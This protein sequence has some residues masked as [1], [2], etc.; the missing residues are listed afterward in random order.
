VKES[1][2]ISNPEYSVD[3]ILAR[4]KDAAVRKGEI[5][6]A[7]S[8]DVVTSAEFR[9]RR[10]ESNS[11]SEL[12]LQPIQLQ[13]RFHPNTDSRYH[14]NDLLKFHDK[15]FIQNAYRAI[16]KRGPDAVG[17]RNFLE[18]LRAAR[19]NKID[20]LARLRYSAEGKAK[21]VEVE[22]LW[23]PAMIRKA[24]RV[25]YV[26]YLLNMLVGVAR[27][28]VLI[29]NQQQFE[30]HMLAQQDIIVEHLNHLNRTLLTHANEVLSLAERSEQ[31][32][33]E[34]REQINNR[35]DRGDALFRHLDARID[36][37]RTSRGEGI[38]TIARRL[39]QFTTRH[40]QLELVLKLK[41]AQFQQADAN[42]RDLID[43]HRQQLELL[44]EQ[45]D[46]ITRQVKTELSRLIEKQQSLNTE[47]V[48]QAERLTTVLDEAR[49]RLPEPFD[50]AQLQALAKEANHT[51]D[52]FYAS[53]DEKFR[54]SRDEIKK[55]LRIYLPKIRE[56]E[57][58][59]ESMP[60]L[61][62]GSGRGEWLEL[63]NE[64]GI[65]ARGVDSNRILVEDCLN[66]GLNVVEAD[67]VLHLQQLADSSIGAVTGFHIIEHLPIETLVEFLNQTVRVLKP[68]GAVIFETPNPQNVLVGSCNF[69]FDPT[70]RNP[71]PSQVTR[72]LVESRGF[73]RVEIL[74]LNPSDDTPVEETSELARR[75]NNYFYGPM[76]YAVIGYRP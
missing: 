24:Y 35:L 38:D 32:I 34:T 71:L 20:I 67:L 11:L 47:V 50:E 48:L 64:E 4:M 58:G 31:Q 17:Y 39:D 25:P 14:V 37:E 70:H 65:V 36:E 7:A 22:G 55:R 23:L 74:N 52:G 76:D 27:L 61:D 45:L 8:T 41:D 51:L 63:L 56:N 40:K 29:R 28:P 21:Q 3:R 19:L 46:G 26:G 49:K 68:G 6:N 9:P 54:G 30:A 5:P 73:T 18:S 12:D 1:A 33:A 75:F 60:V 2:Q 44:R 62:V 59:S 57:I 72:F 66:R 53:F 10:R 69:Y 42:Q 15:A 16:L 13:P 43:A